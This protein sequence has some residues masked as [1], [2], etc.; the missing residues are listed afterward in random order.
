[1][2]KSLISLAVLAVIGAGVVRAKTRDISYG[3]RMGAGFPGDINRTHPAAI[4]PGQ[5]DSTNPVAAYGFPALNS[6]TNTMR[7]LLAA[8]QASLTRIDGVLVRPFPTQQMSGG[9]TSSI[10]AATP[11]TTGIHD[12]L[13]QGLVMATCNNFA[14]S[15]PVKGGRVYVWCAA[16]SG[17]HV[18]GGFEAAAS[19]GNTILLTNAKWQSPADSAGV[20]ELEVW[21]G[22]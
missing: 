12:F 17:Q 22:N 4:L 8:D 18:L 1:M 3:Y 6:G 11:G 10:G 5:M 13:T 7:G 16:S 20:A 21:A 14:A 9:M 2:K 15:P 19:S